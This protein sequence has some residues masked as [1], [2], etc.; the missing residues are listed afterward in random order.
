MSVQWL[1]MVAGVMVVLLTVALV[2]RGVGAQT[3]KCKFKNYQHERHLCGTDL[4]INF[5]KKCDKTR[6]KRHL[7]KENGGQLTR[8]LNKRTAT[9]F[10]TRASADATDSMLCECCYK[11]CRDGHLVKFCHEL[12]DI[13][14]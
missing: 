13:D 5:L 14:I 1:V 2:N 12:D 10:L 7:L 4:A 3:A 6:T 9:S 8:M 11:P